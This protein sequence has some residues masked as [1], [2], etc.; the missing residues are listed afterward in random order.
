MRI[1]RYQNAKADWNKYATDQEDYNR[2]QDTVY[3]RNIYD[4]LNYEHSIP[5][6]APLLDPSVMPDYNR[7]KEL[8]KRHKELRLTVPMSAA[9]AD[10]IV[11][12][13]SELWHLK[14]KV[15]DKIVPFYG[16]DITYPDAEYPTR[17]IKRRSE[18][19]VRPQGYRK[20][21]GFTGTGNPQWAWEED[22]L[23]MGSMPEYPKPIRNLVAKEEQPW[24]KEAARKATGVEGSISRPLERYVVPTGGKREDYK[25]TEQE[26]QD[27]LA[28]KTGYTTTITDQGVQQKKSKIGKRTYEGSPIYFEEI[29]GK[30]YEVSKDRYDDLDRRNK[31]V[32]Q[33]GG[34]LSKAQNGKILNHPGR[35][36]IPDSISPSD[37]W[38]LELPDPENID[39]KYLEKNPPETV[40]PN[41]WVESEDFLDWLKTKESESP[42]DTLY[43]VPKD[44][45]YSIPQ[46]TLFQEPLMRGGGPLPKAQ[47]G[48]LLKT[49]EEYFPAAK[50]YADSL[51]LSDW[52]RDMRRHAAPGPIAW[53][54]AVD[55]VVTDPDAL[56]KD[57]WLHA[58]T[59]SADGDFL[60]AF[61]DD[62]AGRATQTERIV[63]KYFVHP[64]RFELAGVTSQYSNKFK[65]EKYLQTPI[66]NLPT[67]FH[68]DEIHLIP[69]F[70]EPVQPIAPKEEQPW[71]KENIKNQEILKKEGLYKGKLDGIWGK[72]SKKA[73]DEYQERLISR[74]ENKTKKVEDLKKKLFK[75]ERPI[76]YKD[77]KDD[78][79][80]K[81]FE[82]TREQQE[83]MEA[84]PFISI[85]DITE[86]Y[87]KRK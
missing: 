10:E 40:D 31:T 44:T 79:S 84:N 65:P 24:F 71:Y 73:W 64:D 43:T 33:A 14:A 70:K 81:I 62:L 72:N 86:E 29:D 37:L 39:W 55:E 32:K 48:K 60:S 11:R 21:A 42:K 17:F 56:K 4:Q 19:N 83:R 7:I 36:I 58:P 23:G 34:Y 30:K 52:S 3:A 51:A 15:E 46:D 38:N 20:Y 78:G 87:Q 74:E 28:G 25:A 75:G 22:H 45:L 61:T 2:Y 50:A 5:K 82:I 76:I 16:E 59:P 35:N 27:V 6:I 53:Q 49:Q 47:N 12:T 9:E 77:V 69:Q 54:R 80:V 18:T 41:R 63:P 67:R 68:G 85:E 66:K 8:E 57:W 1:P 26:Q 13:A